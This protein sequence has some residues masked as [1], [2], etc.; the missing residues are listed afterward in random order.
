MSINH[1]VGHDNV[2]LATAL[3]PTI[4]SIMQ[5]DGVEDVILMAITDKTDARESIIGSTVSS[6]RA[7]AI[8]YIRFI[9][10][11]L[12]SSGDDDDDLGSSILDLVR[13]AVD[14]KR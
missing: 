3:G 6:T 10:N 4:D 2:H 7:I 5:L 9:I 8:E 11:E 14:S 1:K 13:E 12:Q